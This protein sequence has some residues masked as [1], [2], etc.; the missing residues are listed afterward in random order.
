MSFKTDTQAFALYVDDGE[1]NHGYVNSD[2]DLDVWQGAAERFATLEEATKALADRRIL[3][4]TRVMSRVVT[5]YVCSVP[6]PAPVDF[7]R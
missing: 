1:G 4:T 5:G 6:R 3:N 2:G 7:T